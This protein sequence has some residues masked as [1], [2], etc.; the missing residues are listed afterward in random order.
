M[1]GT[2]GVKLFFGAMNRRIFLHGDF[3]CSKEDH[4]EQQQIENLLDNEQDLQHGDFIQVMSCYFSW[5]LHCNTSLS[6]HVTIKIP[7]V[8]KSLLEI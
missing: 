8:L 3:A 4:S 7:G 2:E 5:E 6:M 1:T